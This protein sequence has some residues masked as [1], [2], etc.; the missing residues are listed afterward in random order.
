M[1][2]APEAVH[3]R[4]L[5]GT[6]LCS[7]VHRPTT[8][9]AVPQSVAKEQM[10]PTA[11]RTVRVRKGQCAYPR[12]PSSFS[13]SSQPVSCASTTVSSSSF[14]SGGVVPSPAVSYRARTTAPGDRCAMSTLD[15]ET[16]SLRYSNV[17]RKKLPPLDH[18]PHALATP[19]WKSV[20]PHDTPSCTAAEKA[21][22]H[23]LL[24]PPLGL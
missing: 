19:R 9:S 16:S 2:L 12:V 17:M 21:T 23:A 6:A 7:R 3:R 15:V 5:R 13:T 10:N 11:K 18:V 24:R 14:D 20:L 1:W 4:L 22:A 8:G